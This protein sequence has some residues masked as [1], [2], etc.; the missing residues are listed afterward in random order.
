MKLDVKAF[1]LS[2]GLLWAV[3]VF[4]LAMLDASL[5]FGTQWVALIATVYK[6]YGP[7]LTG[8]LA[9]MPWA[10]ID[11]FIGALLWAWLYNR[12]AKS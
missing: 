3:G 4:L 12:L 1:A 2:L 8:A 10:F 6:G 9:G 5:G 11:A 7:G